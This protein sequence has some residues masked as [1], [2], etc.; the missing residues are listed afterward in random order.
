MI[1][2]QIKCKYVP[3]KIWVHYQKRLKKK[4]TARVRTIQ[5]RKLKYIFI[6]GK[7]AT[8]LPSSR[9]INLYN[10][11]KKHLTYTVFIVG[12]WAFKEL[13]KKSNFIGVLGVH[14]SMTKFSPTLHMFHIKVWSMLS[15]TTQQMWHSEMTWMPMVWWTSMVGSLLCKSLPSEGRYSV[16]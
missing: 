7:W 10:T 2:T 15:K 3:G 12:K 4:R 9:K 5:N 6:V 14:K 8:F 11:K 1:W 16:R 13:K